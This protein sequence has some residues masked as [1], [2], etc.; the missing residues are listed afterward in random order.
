MI[1]QHTQAA[2]SDCPCV[3]ELRIE[4]VQGGRIVSAMRPQAPATMLAAVSCCS[5]LSASGGGTADSVPR[6]FHSAR[7]RTN[8][9]V[10]S[11]ALISFFRRECTANNAC[12]YVLSHTACVHG[13][14]SLAHSIWQQQ[15]AGC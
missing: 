4:P 1:T 9:V 6:N 12:G 5:S 15:G 10:N 11:G 14:T 3:W 7:S 2:A 8:S 13:C